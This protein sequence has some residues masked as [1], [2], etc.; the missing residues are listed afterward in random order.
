MAAS[1]PLLHCNI[2]YF[3][4]IKSLIEDE[5]IDYHPQEF[6]VAGEGSASRT[7]FISPS[8]A[9]CLEDI[10][11]YHIHGNV[12]LILVEVQINI[13]NNTERRKEQLVQ[14]NLT[15]DLIR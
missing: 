10:I 9:H 6:P 3:F 15:K 4:F 14:T 1:Y 2:R 12:R 5:D 13:P 7:S 11:D 8:S